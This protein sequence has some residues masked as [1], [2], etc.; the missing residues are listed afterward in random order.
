MHAS[1]ESLRNRD[2]K[3]FRNG[4]K[5]FHRMIA[6]FPDNVYLQSMLLTIKGQGAVNGRDGTESASELHCGR[7]GTER[8][9]ENRGYA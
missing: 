2:L 9:V 1:E 6:S 4:N 8:V 7:G 5:R 3:G